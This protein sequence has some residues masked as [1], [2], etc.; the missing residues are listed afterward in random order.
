MVDMTRYLLLLAA[1]A[2]LL[3]LAACGGAGKNDNSGKDRDDK[4]YDGALKFAKCLR[5]HG[6]DAP[7][8]VRAA[9]GGIRQ[10]I[11]RPGGR[12]KR[13]GPGEDTKMQAADK[14]CAKYRVGGG[15]APD[16]AKLAEQRDAFVAYAR[17]MRG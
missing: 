5:D 4:A 1:L 10:R 12:G 3:T 6:I 11:G 15:D 13:P 8:P 9:D 2:G 7:D 14:A 16:P 17:C